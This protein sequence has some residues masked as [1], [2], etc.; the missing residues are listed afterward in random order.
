MSRT[1]FNAVTV[2]VLG[3]LLGGCGLTQK[4]TDATVST[5]QSIFYKQVTTLHLDF[6]GRAA[7]NTDVTDMSGLSV[8]TLVRVYQLRDDT[9]IN[10][11]TYERVLSD[12]DNLLSADLLDQRAQVVKPGEG[13]QLNMP[14][15]KDAKFVTVVALFRNPDTVKNTW[16]LTLS[17]EDLDP[18][19]ARVIEL[20]NNRLTLQ[21]P[22]EK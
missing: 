6:T 10:K 15:H 9:L 13:A 20:G 7:M 14:M 5:T 1:V 22:V 8:P 2:A 11:A 4:V 17:R 12:A 18:D 21:T 19:Q 3:A 16:R